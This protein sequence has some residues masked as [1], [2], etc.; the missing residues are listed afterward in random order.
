MNQVD[1]DQAVRLTAF[2]WLAEK[3]RAHGEILPHSVLDEG[4]T[5]DDHQFRLV[6]P[7]GIFKPAGLDLP[8]TIK[9][10]PEVPGQPRPYE[11]EWVSDVLLRYRYRGTD[12]FHRDNVGLR[13]LM[14]EQRPLIYLDGIARGLYAPIWPVYI[15]DDDPVAHTFIVADESRATVSVGQVGEPARAYATRLTRQRLHQVAFRQ[16]VITAYSE[17]CAICR[18]RHRELLDAAHILADTHERGVP[19]VSNGLSLCKLHHAAFDQNIVG[20]RPDY[21]VEVREDVLHEIDGPMLIHGL[22]GFQG[23]SLIVP[24]REEWK[25]DRDALAER[26]DEFRK[27]G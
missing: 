8:L 13:R 1:H 25:P 24:R 19:A 22:Q 27:V 5:F 12:P 18:L 3:T 17:T 2:A 26:Y 6:G 10:V 9:T 14:E 4:F 11:D 16:R 7:Q 21:V 20:V 15:V 23:G